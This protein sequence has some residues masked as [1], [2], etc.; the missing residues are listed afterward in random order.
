[1]EYLLACIVHTI[2]G[3]QDMIR[4]LGRDI[5]GLFHHSLFRQDESMLVSGLKEVW[6]T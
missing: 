4:N 1:M 2:N 5:L 3:D 6:V